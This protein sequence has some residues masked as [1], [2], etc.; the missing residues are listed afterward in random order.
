MIRKWK[1]I[2]LLI[3]M[4][5]HIYLQDGRI[6]VI[7]VSLCMRIHMN[8]HASAHTHTHTH[9]IIIESYLFQFVCYCLSPQVFKRCFK[10][11]IQ[12]L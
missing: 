9:T 10:L 5:T 3:I 8:M 6:P 11:T 2:L 12:V 4:F 1:A 7:V